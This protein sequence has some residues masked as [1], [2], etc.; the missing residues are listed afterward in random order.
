MKIGICHSEKTELVRD[1]LGLLSEQGNYL[2]YLS[3]PL[4]Y[5]WKIPSL[6]EC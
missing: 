5:L 3:M 1:I 4:H 2:W 6:H